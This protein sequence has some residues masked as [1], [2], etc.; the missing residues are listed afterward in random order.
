MGEVSSGVPGCGAQIGARWDSDSLMGQ[1][2][3]G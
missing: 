1:I 3:F 2:P